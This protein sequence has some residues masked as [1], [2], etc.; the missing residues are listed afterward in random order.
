M[1][2]PRYA[3][4]ANCVDVAVVGLFFRQMPI[5]ESLG[6]VEYD[7]VGECS[8]HLHPPWIFVSPHANAL[9]MPGLVLALRIPTRDIHIMHAAVVKRRTLGVVSLLWHMT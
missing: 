4:C 8:V 5:D 1:A 3:L 6:D 2:H 7:S 9:R